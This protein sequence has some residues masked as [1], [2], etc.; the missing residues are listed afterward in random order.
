[1]DKWEIANHLTKLAGFEK[2]GVR[3]RADESD[4]EMS[5]GVEPFSFDLVDSLG[6]V[7]ICDVDWDVEATALDGSKGYY[8]LT[9][10]PEWPD[11]E[12]Q[13]ARKRNP[14]YIKASLDAGL[15]ITDEERKI[16]EDSN[17]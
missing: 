12:F 11:E 9:L 2:F 8:K 4:L 13:E 10:E 17:R 7:R 15:S 14:E 16:L 3:F 1:M 5:S 6:K